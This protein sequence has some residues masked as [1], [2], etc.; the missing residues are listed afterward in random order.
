M[1]PKKPQWQCLGCLLQ[2][3]KEKLKCPVCGQAQP[4][5]TQADT[6]TTTANP[7]TTRYVY[8]MCNALFSRRKLYVMSNYI[9]Y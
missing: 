2:H 8:E 4:G 6:K 9:D 3:D 5:T 1:K 7:V